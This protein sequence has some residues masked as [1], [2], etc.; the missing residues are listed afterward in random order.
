MRNGWLL[1]LERRLHVDA[2][3]VCS[4]QS[5]PCISAAVRRD[6]EVPFAEL[7]DFTLLLADDDRHL[8]LPHPGDL[9]APVDLLLLVRRRRQLPLQ[10]SDPLRPVL[11][12]QPVHP[13]AGDLVDAHQHRLAGFPAVE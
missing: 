2:L 5:P 6:V 12:D 13:H 11:A 3:A 4:R 7:V 8:G 1:L 10:L 9:P